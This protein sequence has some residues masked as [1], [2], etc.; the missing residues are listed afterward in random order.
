MLT[1]WHVFHLLSRCTKSMFSLFLNSKY[2]GIFRSQKPISQ[3][4][5]ILIYPRPLAPTNFAGGG[6]GGGNS[7]FFIRKIQI[8]IM[9]EN[10]WTISF[11]FLLKVWCHALYL[12]DK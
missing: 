4:L 7:K 6:G 1:K 3:I 11:C 9:I 8:Y 2:L 10:G 5:Q 12:S